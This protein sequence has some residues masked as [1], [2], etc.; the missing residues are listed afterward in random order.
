MP[1]FFEDNCDIC[2]KFGICFKIIPK[3]TYITTI[4]EMNKHMVLPK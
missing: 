4:V 2:L 3:G 1:L